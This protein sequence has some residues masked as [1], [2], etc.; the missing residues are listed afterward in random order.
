MLMLLLYVQHGMNLIVG[1]MVKRA[2]S[3]GYA[4]G[5]DLGSSP[6]YE[7]WSFSSVVRF[8]HSTIES[9]RQHL[10]NAP[11]LSSPRL[12]G[13]AC[14]TTKKKKKCAAIDRTLY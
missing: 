6:T 9:Q 3:N 7:Q 5:K 12:S 13:V 1:A 11:Q 14:K 8:L 4:I 10:C 2:F